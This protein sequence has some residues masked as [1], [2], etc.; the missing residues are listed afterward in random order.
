[1]TSKRII[2][3]TS[4]I[5]P[6]LVIGS[7][8]AT[9]LYYHHHPSAL[10]MLIE[11]SVS[12]P[13]GTSLVIGDLSY[14]ISPLSVQAKGIVLEPGAGQ[15]GFYAAIPDLKADMVVTGRFGHKTLTFTNLRIA[16]FSL[17]LS[18]EMTLPE[19][20]PKPETPPS[21]L[22]R[23]LKRMIRFFVFRGVTFQSAEVVNGEIA[24]QST[25]QTVEISD[26]QARISP[27]HGV[28]ASCSARAKWSGEKMHLVI[29]CLHV[30]S[31]SAVYPVDREI[32]GRLRVNQ[33]TL[34]SP[35]GNIREIDI[36]TTFSYDHSREKLAFD[37]THI[38]C[39]EMTLR[40]EA[41]GG[42]L[43][44][45]LDFT[46]Q[47]SLDL[48]GKQIEISRFHLTSKDLLELKG[49]LDLVFG[50]E[51]TVRMTRLDGHLLPNQCLSILRDTMGVR[52]PPFTLSGPVNLHGSIGGTK[53]NQ[54]W[55]WQG[56]I[57]VTL[58]RNRFS[59]VAEQM[60]STGRI[61]GS[62]RAEGSFPDMDL[63]VSLKGDETTFSGM[64][65]TVKPCKARVSL[66]GKH[67]LYRVGEVHVA[68]PQATLAMGSR[69]IQVD[70][71]QVH[72]QGGTV[73][74]EKGAVSV[75]EV[76]LTSSVLKNL[77]LLLHID[78][79]GVITELKGED[80]HLAEAALA[81]GLTPSGWEF[82]GL[83]SLKARAVLKDDDRLA[84]TAT[85][86]FKDFA[87]LDSSEN[88][89]GEGILVQAG[90][91]AEI[92]L[93]R[94]SVT[95]NTIL[96]I[97]AGEVLW[98]NFYFNLAKNPFSVSLKSAY[99]MEKKSLQLSKMIIGLK[100]ILGLH[101]HG[102]IHHQTQD[103]G[104]D[105]IVKIEE[106]PLKPIY[107]HFVSEP[108]RMQNPFLASM[109]T[110]G[111]ISAEMKLVGTPNDLTAKGNFT[112]HDGE[113]L[114]GDN[115]FSLR[116]I[117]FELPLW[118]QTREDE[119]A[120]ETAKGTLS[121]Q[122][123]ILPF[124]PEQP[125][126][127]PLDA[128][129]NRL[130]VRSPTIIGIPGG[131]V[132]VGPVTCKD[133]FGAKRSVSTSLEVTDIEIDE[134][135]PGIWSSPIQ[136]TISG[137]LD[138]IYFGGDTLTS[139]GEMKADAFS[140]QLILSRIGASRLSTS[141][142][143]FRLDA[144]WSDLSLEELTTDTSFGRIDGV[145]QGYVKG[146]EIAYGQPQAFDL[147]METVK[148]KGVP[149][150]ISVKAVDNIAQIGGGTS[151]F[152][153]LAGQFARFFKE[154][155]YTKIGIHASLQNDVFR[156]N[157]TV[158]EGGTEYLV[159]RGSFSGINVVNRNPDN[160]VRFK[161]MVKRIQRVTDSDSGPVM[162]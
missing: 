60:R 11:K 44:T 72:A 32:N 94:S 162:K 20:S 39:D 105:L 150:K 127:L 79:R 22:S 122:S 138:P 92:D 142:P 36:T 73:N 61:S 147:L 55:L 37:P 116:G 68:V 45:D 87:F 25:D 82:S 93:K 144:K 120:E 71:I 114:S 86:G 9:I 97:D 57:E 161:D 83:D 153:G 38:H 81:L 123:M 19:I 156:I 131:D 8:T 16:D 78:E 103:P 124:L 2:L 84:L 110:K 129:P 41:D 53:E 47:G 158:K 63:S 17:R 100:D 125:L 26:I 70:D 40:Q 46:A 155:P 107:H 3:L 42:F 113:L 106:T 23:V 18:S 4:C 58:A 146:M 1:M 132:T 119:V 137:T 159:K 49:E 59:Y 69:D 135:L 85:L 67:P 128:G 80:T 65:V 118:Y 64:G 108:F 43:S 101:I 29:P 90:S 145:L 154:F 34:E 77:R 140:G 117:E 10:K 15:H 112:W 99:G 48:A 66:T 133:I 111:S 31:D 27:E 148:T 95:A 109:H 151:P 152:M 76:R 52:L 89:M 62:L 88:G 115:S 56:D 98:D 143:V 33:A 74:A 134:L 14:S 121:V 136:G 104:V 35:H 5:I 130:F 30:T 149:Q 126:N 54:A 102:S 21:L 160:Q 141:G 24:F 91:E 13:T 157:G 96:K 7:L 51:S 50:T 75:P 6:I 139:Q 28:D 12:G